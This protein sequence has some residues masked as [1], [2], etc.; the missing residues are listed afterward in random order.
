MQA[1]ART[2][3][4]E[5]LTAPPADRKSR[6]V[7]GGRAGVRPCLLTQRLVRTL[8]AVSVAVK[9]SCP[10][11]PLRGYAVTSKAT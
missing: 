5:A 1:V 3:P 10:V 6:A 4:G 7:A 11:V 2:E 9:Y 8:K